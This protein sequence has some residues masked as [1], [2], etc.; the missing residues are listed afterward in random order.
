MWSATNDPLHISRP[1]TW[2]R[3]AQKSEQTRWGNFKTNLCWSTVLSTFAIITIIS[4]C[5]AVSVSLNEPSRVL[6]GDW[7]QQ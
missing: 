2:Y 1:E 5:K 3:E 4:C 6:W 7:E